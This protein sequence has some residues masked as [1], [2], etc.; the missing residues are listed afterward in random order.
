MKGGMNWFVRQSKVFNTILTAASEKV[1][2]ITAREG[3]MI[4]FEV[5]FIR[6]KSKIEPLFD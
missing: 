3:A 4:Q 5:L 2:T 1:S 6:F